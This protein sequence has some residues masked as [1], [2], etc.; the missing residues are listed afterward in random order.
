MYFKRISEDRQIRVRPV[1]VERQ[2]MNNLLEDAADVFACRGK[3][4]EASNRI[5]D[6][7]S[8]YKMTQAFSKL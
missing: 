5:M 8:P 7:V 6:C 3:A 1:K 4:G 2:D